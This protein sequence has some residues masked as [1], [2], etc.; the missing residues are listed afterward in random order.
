MVEADF[1]DLGRRGIA[2]DMPAQLAVGLVGPCHHG[3]GVPANDRGDALFH[4][5]VTGEYRLVF[6]GDAVL[7]QRV[8]VG[9]RAYAE[10]AGVFGQALQQE[11]DALAA[12]AA[13]D[14]LQGVEP[15]VGFLAV[16]VVLGAI[17]RYIGDLGSH[18]LRL[19]Q[20]FQAQVAHGCPVTGRPRATWCTSSPIR[21]LGCMP[22]P[23][24]K[25]A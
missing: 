24:S 25:G 5:Q 1:E 18:G 4:C 9:A 23:S 2:G 17:A 20:V 22:G 11:V 21:H 12:S 6:Q 13:R 3:Q 15:F 14:G 8:R 19:N 16:A 7:V 10:V